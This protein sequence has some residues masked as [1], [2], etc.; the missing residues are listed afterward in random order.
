MSRPVL[1]VFAKGPR[2]G[3]GKTR[4]AQRIGEAQAL[5][6]NRFLQALTLRRVRD[7]RWEVRLLVGAA[8]DLEA[9][10]PGVWPSPAGSPKREPQATGDLGARLTAAFDRPG[11]VG[12]I[13]ADCPE[14]SVQAIAEGFKALRR[15]PFALGPAADGGFWFFAARQARR[16]QPAF[17]GVRW[18][19][20]HAAE[21]LIE[22]LPGPVALTRTLADIDEW[23]D[24]R[25]YRARRRRGA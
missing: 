5:R 9:R 1:L 21:D 22:R 25:A 18:S 7:P 20:P 24:W 23:E 16:A 19:S 3:A 2:L 17:G 13:G 11:A 8:Q 12:V 4:L 6:L 10:F 15:A 14:V